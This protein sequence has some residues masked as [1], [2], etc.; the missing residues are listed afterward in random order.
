MLIFKAVKLLFEA[1]A[2]PLNFHPKRPDGN[3]RI[4]QKLYN[5]TTKVLGLAT[6]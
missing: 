3:S 1:I 4:G 2:K 6:L 5:L